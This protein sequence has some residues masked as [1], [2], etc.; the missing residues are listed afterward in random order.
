[1]QVSVREYYQHCHSWIEEF[2]RMM[3]FE[4]IESQM[5]KHNRSQPATSAGAPPQVAMRGLRL[6]DF[7]KT[8]KE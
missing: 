6:G 7:R 4:Q 8:K 3:H 1:M 2:T 5:R